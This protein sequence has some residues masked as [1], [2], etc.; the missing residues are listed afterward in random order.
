MF[1]FDS[2]F[3]V[4]CL[5]SLMLQ[6]PRSPLACVIADGVLPLGSLLVSTDVRG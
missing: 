5:G 4:P 2:T 3:S 1:S 6:T